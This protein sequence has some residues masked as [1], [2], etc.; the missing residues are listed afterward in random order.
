MVTF[1]SLKWSYNLA[2]FRFLEISPS[3]LPPFSN[4]IWS[5]S[6]HWNPNPY[7]N[8]PAIKKRYHIH[9]LWPY[10]RCQR[11]RMAMLTGC[12]IIVRQPKLVT[13]SSFEHWI[14]L[15]SNIENYEWA[16][17]RLSRHV[18]ENMELILVVDND[19]ALVSHHA[20][21]VYLHTYFWLYAGDL[22]YLYCPAIYYY[23]L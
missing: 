5:W 3:P 6:N 2:N 14:K 17:F 16:A 10:Q 11:T 23:Y 18:L 12:R 19:Y 13:P 8:T 9:F 1:N 22:V 20:P 7:Y 15:M 21:H 4:E